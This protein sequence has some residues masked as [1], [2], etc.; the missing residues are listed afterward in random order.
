M[1]TVRVTPTCE[2]SFAK[3]VLG[4]FASASV[5]PMVR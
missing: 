5:T 4:D 1:S 2:M 3:A